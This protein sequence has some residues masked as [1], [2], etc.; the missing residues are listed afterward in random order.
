MASDSIVS[1]QIASGVCKPPEYMFT[2]VNG[3]SY[4]VNCFSSVNIFI[5]IS[6]W[7]KLYKNSLQQ[8]VQNQRVSWDKTRQNEEM[9]IKIAEL[10]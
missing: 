6:C 3:G 7:L 1:F 4:I 8:H 9:K 5:I 10:K 2:Y